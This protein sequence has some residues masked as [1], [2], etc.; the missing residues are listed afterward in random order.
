MFGGMAS[1]A[2]FYNPYVQYNEYEAAAYA[3]FHR[4]AWGLG[5]VGL[6]FVGGYGY[7]TVI[8]KVLT[9]SPWIPLSKLVYGAYLIHI[10]FQIRAVGMIRHVRFF[11]Y[12]DNV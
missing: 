6:L 9:W 7:A 8:Q 12:F 11:S 1:G 2:I 5:T 4:P 10:N 3:A